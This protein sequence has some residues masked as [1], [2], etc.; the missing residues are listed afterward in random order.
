MD[1]HVVAFDHFPLH[2]EVWLVLYGRVL[3]SSIREEN[4]E[5][6]FLFIMRFESKV[7]M[8]SEDKT[9]WQELS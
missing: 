9:Q 5:V 4:E 6:D 1:L 3:R 8:L 7:E 2:H